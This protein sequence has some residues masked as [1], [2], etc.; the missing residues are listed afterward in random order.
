MEAVKTSS[1]PYAKLKGLICEKFE[2]NKAFAHALYMS[3]ASLSAKLNNRSEWKS[4]E[5]AR[6]CELLGIPLELAHEYFF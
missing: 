6:A 3:R 4:D 1:R 2:T 5:I